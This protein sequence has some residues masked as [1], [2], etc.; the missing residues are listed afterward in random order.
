[1]AKCPQCG[2]YVNLEGQ[3]CGSCKR[4]KRDSEELNRLRIKETKM[5]IKQNRNEGGTRFHFLYCLLIGW[6][7]S[8]MLICFIVPLFFPGGR[9]LIK[10]A[11]GIW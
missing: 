6:W 8:M 2:D 1:M 9:R 11:F 5:N 7:L 4:G 10:K 3:V